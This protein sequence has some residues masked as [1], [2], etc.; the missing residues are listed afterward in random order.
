[1]KNK[2]V[3]STYSSAIESKK[4]NKQNRIRV[5][6]TDNVMMVARWERGWEDG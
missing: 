2:N 3:I 4:T 5:I 6:D 1:M